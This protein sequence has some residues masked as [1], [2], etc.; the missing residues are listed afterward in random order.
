LSSLAT[1]GFAVF[2][3]ILFIGIY[4]SLFGLPGTVIIFIDVLT[5]AVITGFDRIGVQ[6]LLF[7]LVFAIMA[8]MV[9]FLMGMTGALR[10]T[11]SKKLF[12][13]SAIGSIAG[14]FILTPLLWGLGTFGGFY[15]GCLA[16]ILI[17]EFIR[18]SKLQAS[19]QATNRAILIMVGG[20]MVKGCIALVMIAV[21]L[22][23]IYS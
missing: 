6:I 9:D 14:M 19:F 12:W 15:L 4:L 10:L 20:K 17:T 8:E 5:Y 23:N 18:Q 13:G 22:S 1:F 3:L 7:L 2:I 11:P 16:G 21:S